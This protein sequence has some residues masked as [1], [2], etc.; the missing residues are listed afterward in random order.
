MPTICV[1]IIITA[2][3]DLYPCTK[4]HTEGYPR[5]EHCRD[6]RDYPWRAVRHRLGEVQGEAVG[7]TRRRWRVR[8]AAD[9][10]H[11]QEFSVAEDRSRRSRGSRKLFSPVHGGCFRRSAVQC[12]A[13]DSEMLINGEHAPT[14]VSR[15]R[16]GGYG[17]PRKPGPGRQ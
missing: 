13:R 6:V 12:R 3:A 14:Q 1:T 9:P 17:V 15:A 2:A 5:D 4:M 10:G 8:H 11:H 7:R 16:S